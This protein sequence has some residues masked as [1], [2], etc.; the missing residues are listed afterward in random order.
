[1]KI[2]K[3]I[4]EKFEDIGFIKVK[5]D[6]HGVTYE[7]IMPEKYTQKLVLHHNRI[8]GNHI[9]Q[10]YDPALFDEKYIGNVGVGLS[11]YEIKLCYKK[12]K[13]MGWKIS[14]SKK[15]KVK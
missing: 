7:R 15:S 1:M 5:E 8:T 12:M 6:L 14:D 3:S 10:S 11:M 2:F 4:D 9:V 13:K